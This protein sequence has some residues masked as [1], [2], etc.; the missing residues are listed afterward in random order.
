[1][2]DDIDV[3]GVQCKSGGAGID[4]TRARIGIIMNTGML[5]PGG[6]DQML[7]RQYRPGQTRN[8]VFYRLVSPKTVETKLYDDRGKK[9][10]VNDAVMCE[11]LNEEEEFF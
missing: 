6:E 9:R 3:M 11:L 5:T 8:V 4:L 1:M 7:A 10:Q 2:P